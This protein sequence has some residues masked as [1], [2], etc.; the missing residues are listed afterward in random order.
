MAPRLWKG[1]TMDNV[2]D[3]KER[4][5]ESDPGSMMNGFM[6]AICSGIGG[7]DEL[8]ISA[9]AR[10]L[11]H[12][13]EEDEHDDARASGQGSPKQR[14]PC[15]FGSGLCSVSPSRPA[16]EIMVALIPCQPRVVLA[17]APE[18]RR[19]F[20]SVAGEMSPSYGGSFRSLN[21]RSSARNSFLTPKAGIG[22]AETRASAQPRVQ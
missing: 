13:W 20:L 5:T 3:L 4:N 12:G 22:Q 15:L 21:H 1:K 8:G 14:T 19:R 9:A 18:R 10:R 2:E 11:S 7:I 17:H 6:S 16:A